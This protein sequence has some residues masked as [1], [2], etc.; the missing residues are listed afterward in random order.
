V[1]HDFEG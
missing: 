1:G